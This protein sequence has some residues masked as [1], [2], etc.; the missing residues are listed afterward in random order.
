[1]KYIITES[2][3]NDFIFQYLDSWSENKYINGFDSLITITHRD[4]GN[5]INDYFE[6]D[7]I[8]EYSY[9]DG[10][11]YIEKD[12]RNHFMD[13]FNKSS[14]EANSFIKDWF[15]YKFGEKVEYVD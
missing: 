6:E 9:E 12:F 11:L 10:R 3:L 1:M 13:L 2:R 5:D 4:N 7:V 14:D 15:E 8:I